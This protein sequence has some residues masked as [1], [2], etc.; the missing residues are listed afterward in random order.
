[1]AELDFSV[2]HRTGT[3]NPASLNRGSLG[4]NDSG[5]LFVGNSSNQPVKQATEAFAQPRLSAGTVNQ[6]RLGN[7]TL[8][9]AG[10]TTQ[11]IRGDGTLAPVGTSAQVR[12]GDNSVQN[13]VDLQTESGRRIRSVATVD[14]AHI[15]HRFDNLPE[16]TYFSQGVPLETP[17]LPSP[18]P[19][20][21]TCQRWSNTNQLTTITLVDQWNGAEWFG[22]WVDNV[23]RGFRLVSEPPTSVDSI[24]GLRINRSG[25]LVSISANFTG[26]VQTNTWLQ[27]IPVGFRPSRNRQATCLLYQGASVLLGH[28]DIPTDGRIIITVLGGVSGAHSTLITSDSWI[29]QA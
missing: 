25:N 27:A 29:A 17:G 7:N 19:Y 24:L 6:L 22:Q 15:A 21:I 5:E 23:W 14:N 28:I 9:T 8:S 1:M 16:G 18:H 26:S 2:F 4:I 3:G 12:R 13:I 20:F 11:L 10:A